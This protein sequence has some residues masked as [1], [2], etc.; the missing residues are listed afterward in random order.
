MSVTLYHTKEWIHTARQ[1]RRRAKWQCE[2]CGARGRLEVHHKKP[3]LEGGA[4]FDM[5]N[6]VCLC[7]TC[8]ISHH[9]GP[10]HKERAKWEKELQKQIGRNSS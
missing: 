1:A 10:Q 9:H 3:V 7:R 6:L 4:W 8:H 2:W 5:E